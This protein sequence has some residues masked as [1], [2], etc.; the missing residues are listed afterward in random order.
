MLTERTKRRQHGLEPVDRMPKLE[1]QRALRNSYLAEDA[2]WINFDTV[3]STLPG[4]IAI[5]PGYL[6]KEWEE[7]GRRYFHYTMDAP[8]QNF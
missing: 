1:D 8:I 7:N 3:V 5:A 6:E 2:D 4:Q